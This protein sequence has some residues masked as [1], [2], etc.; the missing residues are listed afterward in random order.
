MR[1][2]SRARR[3]EDYGRNASRVYRLLPRKNKLGDPWGECVTGTPAAI[4]TVQISRR[5]AEQV[6]RVIIHIVVDPY[7]SVVLKLY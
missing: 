2:K 5:V 7:V 1:A 6:L 4:V 3:I